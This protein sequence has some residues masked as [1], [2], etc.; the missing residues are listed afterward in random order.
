[1]FYIDILLL[2]SFDLG[3]LDGV[4]SWPNRISVLGNGMM[5]HQMTQSNLCHSS[6]SLIPRFNCF[7]TG[8]HHMSSFENTWFVDIFCLST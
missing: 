4:G 8:F 1:M 3:G 6:E 7:Y 5:I 2:G